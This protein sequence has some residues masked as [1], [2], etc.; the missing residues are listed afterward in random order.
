MKI[1]TRAIV[2]LEIK[3]GTVVK[4]I[5]FEGLKKIGDPEVLAKKYYKA[6]AD[7]LVISDVVASLYE[8]NIHYETLKKI[9]RNIF[10][11]IIYLGGIKYIEDIEACLKNGADRIAINSVLFKKKKYNL[12]KEAVK[13]F[14]SQCIILNIEAKK[15]NNEW[16][17]MY[18]GGKSLTDV[19]IDDHIKLAIDLGVGELLI[20]SVDKDGTM[21]SFDFDL[22]NKVYKK[23]YSVPVT[24]S[25]GAGSIDDFKNLK[26]YEVD[27]VCFS[28]ILHYNKIT[29]DRIKKIF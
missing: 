27:G 22:I 19:K 17:C 12:L 4:P 7:E 9:S 13:L 5:C 10:I 23:K 28:S 15:I 29:I 14:G 3:T 2:K 11:P 20:Q 25:G 21:N 18:D 6:G 16:Y 24:I 26:K 1:K 8:R